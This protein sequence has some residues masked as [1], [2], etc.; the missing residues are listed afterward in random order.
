MYNNSTLWT[1]GDLIMSFGTNKIVYEIINRFFDKECFFNFTF[2]KRARLLKI[3]S[4][5]PIPR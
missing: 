2:N 1:G 5:I 3:L 4:L